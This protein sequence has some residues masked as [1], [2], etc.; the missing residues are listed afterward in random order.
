[1]DERAVAERVARVEGALEA[2]EG[3]P[4][5]P[6]G[7][8]LEAVAALV[9]LYG[10]GWARALEAVEAACPGASASLAGDELV[11]HLLMVHGLHPVAVEARVRG[12]LEEVEASVNA[13]GLTLELLGVEDGVA[14]LRF[15]G[16][17]HAAPGLQGLVEGAVL[18]AAPELERVEVEVPPG[19]GP[20]PRRSGPRPAPGASPRP[21]EGV[22]AGPGRAHD[23]GRERGAELPGHAAP[24]GAGGGRHLQALRPGGRHAGCRGALRPVRRAH[25]PPPRP[26]GGRGAAG[27]PVRVP[28]VHHPLPEGRGRREP[29]PARARAG[30]LPGRLHAGRL[31]WLALRVPVDVA[32]F[33]HSSAAGRVVALYPGP[34]GATESLLGL[35]HWERMAPENPELGTW[36]PTWR[37]CWWIGARAGAAAGSFPS[38]LLRAG[39]AVPDPLEG[40]FRRRGGVGRGGDVLRGT[41]PAGATPGGN[42]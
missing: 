28:G 14:R 39:G 6:R 42:P 4:A 30:A 38:T 5:G 36:S 19:F 18:Q 37:R 7:T 10:E 31:D 35:E 13:D 20:A 29:L 33:F 34:M 3:L 2:L 8:A 1:M 11:G 41:A 22:G 24:A 27:A 23:P 17:G 40:T 21:D 16:D 9:E 25:R 15:H 26:P 12:V 32:F